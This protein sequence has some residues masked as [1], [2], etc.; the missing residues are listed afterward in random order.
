MMKTDRH[1]RFATWLND[2]MDSRGMS[3][4]E[5]GRL[6]GLPQ[7]SIHHWTSGRNLPRPYFCNLIADALNIDRDTVLAIAG[8]RPP[9]PAVDP[10]APEVALMAK[11][12]RIEWRPE[13]VQLIGGMLDN[14]ITLYPKVRKQKPP[15]F[16]GEPH[17]LERL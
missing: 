10:L 3:Q 11:I 9:K 17:S 15:Q 7:G 1:R 5:L 2:E 13:T 14:L 6:L 4:S 16:D 12:E 8:H